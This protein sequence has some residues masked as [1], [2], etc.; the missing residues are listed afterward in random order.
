MD[1]GISVVGVGEALAPADVVRLSIGISCNGRDV[2]TALR[3]VASRLAAVAAAARDH[4]VA[5]KDLQTSGA[6]VQPRYAGDGM[7]VVGYSAFHQL[8]VTGRDID[9]AGD[10]VAAF[11]GA[12]GNALTINQ[13]SLTV[14]DQEPLAVRAREAAFSSARAKAEQYAAL[15]GRSLADVLSV[16][17]TPD[18]G[19]GVPF[20]LQAAMA[21][22]AMP[23]ERGESTVRASVT[24]R[25][26]L[27]PAL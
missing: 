11:A 26:S 4:G 14:A 15:A 7:A 3:D 20:R 22:S 10:L 13:I 6:G 5:D 25:W 17:E 27:G 9:R 23:I 16:A 24:V 2:S 8:E 21:D 19:V 18:Q 1:D 12:A